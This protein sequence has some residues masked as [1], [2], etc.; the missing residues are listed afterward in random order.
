M[1][2]GGTIETAAEKSEERLALEGG[3]GELLGRLMM[4]QRPRFMALCR[5]F[6]LFPPQVM[7]L[8]SLDQPRPMRWVADQLACDSSNL[9][10]ITDRLEERGLVRRTAD[11][12]DRRVKLL[13]LT[14]EG[15]RLRTE[16]VERMSPPEALTALSDRDLATMRRILSKAL[17]AES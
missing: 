2:E 4:S 1:A 16:L 7:V 15:E 8:R 10:G 3:V 6:E 14:E 12:G 13:V 11:P 17:A 5:E 9:T